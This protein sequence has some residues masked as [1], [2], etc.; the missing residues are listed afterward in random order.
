M[1][2]RDRLPYELLGKKTN[3]QMARIITFGYSSPVANSKSMQNIEEIAK[4]FRSRLDDLA[5]NNS[6]RP[7]LVIA[8]SLGGLVFKEVRKHSI[9]HPRVPLNATCHCHAN[10]FIAEQVFISLKRAEPE[11]STR[12]RRAICG[13]A[14]FGV[15]H[16]GMK[17]ESLVA[18]ANGGPNL[19][20][21]ASLNQNNSSF[22]T[23]Q[24]EDFSKALKELN[25]PELFCFY[26][27]RK[28]PTAEVSQTCHN[29][30]L[31]HLLAVY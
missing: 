1:W 25:R 6:Q 31:H 9:N 24:A 21:V 14:F 17:I 28:S 3:K 19:E 18:M 27:T 26:E 12:I 4:N 10:V 15:P 23:R 13:I 22:L 20:L 16:H 8:H 11:T 30:Y 29:H 5:L 2:L 7:I